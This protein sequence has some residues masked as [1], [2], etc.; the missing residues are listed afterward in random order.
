GGSTSTMS[1]ATTLLASGGTGV[2]PGQSAQ[3]VAQ[4]VYEANEV[5]RRSA[6]HKRLPEVRA[7]RFIELYL[8]RAT[9]AWEALK[10]LAHATPTRYMVTEPIV[11]GA[12]SLRRPL[13][14]GY[15][16]VDYDFI[17]AETRQD[18]NGNPLIAYALDT[19]RAR[20]E[21]HAQ[22]TQGRLLR[23]LVAT[24]SSEAN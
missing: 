12:G 15:R 7:L 16:G 11:A 19:K 21:V 8:S 6:R 4:G 1:L 9:E 10:M 13:D 14:S 23:D 2:T 22:A 3:L 18:V 5:I 24:A 20:T 17:T